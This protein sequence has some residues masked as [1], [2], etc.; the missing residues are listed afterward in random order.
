MNLAYIKPIIKNSNNNDY[1][2]NF[3]FKINYNQSNSL[4]ILDGVGNSNFTNLVNNELRYQQYLINTINNN[5]NPTNVLNYTNFLTTYIINQYQTIS[6]LFYNLWTAD[7][8]QIKDK[9]SDNLVK[10]LNYV[11]YSTSGRQTFL[12]FTTNTIPF[13]LINLVSL[14]LTYKLNNVKQTITIPNNLINITTNSI[15]FDLTQLI[16]SLQIPFNLQYIDFST[17]YFTYSYTNSVPII[18]SGQLNITNLTSYMDNYL[19]DI[20]TIINNNSPITKQLYG[21][22]I[23]LDFINNL[24]DEMF[25]YLKNYEI[26]RKSIVRNSGILYTT[27]QEDTIDQNPLLQN[28]TYLIKYN[29]DNYFSRYLY[30]KQSQ[31]YQNIY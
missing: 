22:N 17:A 16:L 10:I 11:Q 20:T 14:T 12:T 7:L 25:N 9:L 30:S 21:N 6:T 5:L 4:F 19:N 29:S 24:Y 18:V 31:L 28:N 23:L 15:A 26:S 27:Y 1:L 3:Y 8:L 13:T 2:N